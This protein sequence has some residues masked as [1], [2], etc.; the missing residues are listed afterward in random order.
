MRVVLECEA[1]DLGTAPEAMGRTAFRIVQEG[2]TNA[3]KHADH[4]A[5][6]VAVRGAA[7]EGLTVEIRN[8]W[9]VD[10][11]RATSVPGA[12]MG[13]IGLAERTALIGGR[14]EHGRTA[15]DEFRLWAWL[16]WPT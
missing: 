5:V 11:V 3:R 4:A 9:P 8:P 14:L 2:L 7:A 15:T 10:G 6:S 16:P 12:G 1:T 13:I